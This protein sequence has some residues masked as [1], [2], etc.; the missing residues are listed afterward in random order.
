M[1]E[2]IYTEN[3]DLMVTKPNGLQYKFE[4]VDK[5]ELGFDYDVLVYSNEEFKIVNWHDDKEFQDQ[6][7]EPLSP[8]EKDAVETYIDN[9]E[10][11][12]GV[13][14]NSQYID[15]LSQIANQYLE[16]CS[17]GFS[18]GDLAEVTFV[19][20]EG[21]NHPYRSNARRVM[22]YG[23]A[24]WHIFDQ[25]MQEIVKTRE[26]TLKPFELYVQELPQPQQIPEVTPAWVDG[27]EHELG[28]K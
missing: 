4:N 13:T 15:Q 18:F 11:P 21:S 2:L 24:L 25:L 5:P 10:P 9:S 14:L 7:R 8:D 17:R 22:E 6:E 27:K 19:G 23:D 20:R 16:S 1:N 3:N 12:M 26:D 28:G